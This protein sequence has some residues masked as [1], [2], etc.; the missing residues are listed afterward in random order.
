M[1]FKGDLAIDTEAM[2][3]NNARDRLCVVQIS[4]GSGHAHVVHFPTP[5]F[6]APRLKALLSDDTR[7][8]IFHFGRFDIAILHH[9]LGISANPVY[10]TKIASRLARTFTDRHGFKDLCKDLLGVDV[11]KAQQ[12]SDW[13]AETLSREQVDYA[14]S[15]V[16]HLHAL[17]DKLNIMLLRE[18][19][20][21]LAGECFSFLPARARL[22]L[23]GWPETDIFSH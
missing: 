4:D 23:A 20:M 16:L 22:D 21:D 17:R 19:R 14:A 3:L 7:T 12:S 2:G 10:C 13:G 6:S 18:G 9:Y 15:D 8:K 1:R 5:D 11:S